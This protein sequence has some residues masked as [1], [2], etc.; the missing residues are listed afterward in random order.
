[1]TFEIVED[2]DQAF[3]TKI[4]ECWAT[5]SREADAGDIGYAVIC[6]QDFAAARGLNPK[7]KMVRSKTLMQGH[8]CCNHH[9]VWR[10]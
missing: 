3:E 8:D 7:L 6:H 9:Y 4:A 2:T 5:T 1:L 10:V